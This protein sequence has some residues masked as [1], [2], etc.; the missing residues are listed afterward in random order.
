MNPAFVLPL[1]LILLFA[2]ILDSKEHRIPNWLT[3]SSMALGMICNITLFGMEGLLYSFV[4]I[5]AGLF[6]LILPYTLGV[7]GAGDV[8]LMMALGAWVGAFSVLQIFLW[9]A[10]IG[11]VYA[12]ILMIYHRNL[13]E[14]LLGI[15]LAFANTIK[16]KK[17]DISEYISNST[18]SYIP[19]AIPIALGFIGY[20]T[21]GGLI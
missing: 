11:S 2:A 8:K 17:L 12:A 20:Y 15:K 14:Q 18:P 6:L 21:F 4:G 10:I 3:F 13:S 5:I 19:Y 9:T 1:M 16:V 7:M